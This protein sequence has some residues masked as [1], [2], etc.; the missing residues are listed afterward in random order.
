MI[1]HETQIQ[2]TMRYDHPPVRIAK[3]LRSAHT[4]CGEVQ[5]NYNS[6]AQC[7]M[8]QLLQKTVCLV[9][10]NGKHTLAHDPTILLLVS[11]EMRTEHSHKDQHERSQQLSVEQPTLFISN[12]KEGAID[13]HNT[14]ESQYNN[15]DQ[16]NS[17]K[18]I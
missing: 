11:Q 13:R 5:R 8:E 15:A 1:K 10:K 14:D 7:K 18:H 17:E 16:K 2:T 4:E 12:K 6:H 9:L 3:M